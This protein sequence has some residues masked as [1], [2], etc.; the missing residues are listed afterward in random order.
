MACMKITEMLPGEV[1]YLELEGVSGVISEVLQV[2]SHTLSWKGGSGMISEMLPGEV[3]YL[4]LVVVDL[5]RRC[6]QVRPHTSS[7]KGGSGV[8][9]EVLPGEV[10]YLELEGW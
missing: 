4:E 10:S 5:S 1:P 3:S 2:R 8:V 6:Y 7:W 9:S